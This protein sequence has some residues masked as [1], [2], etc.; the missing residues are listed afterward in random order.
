MRSDALLLGKLLA[1]RIYQPLYV[2][3]FMLGVMNIVE[4]E[5]ADSIP[6]PKRCPREKVTQSSF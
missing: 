4:S 2:D 1:Q 5:M 6:S 3:F